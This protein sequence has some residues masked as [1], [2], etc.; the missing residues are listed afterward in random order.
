MLIPR[1]N[2]AP[3][4]SELRELRPARHIAIFGSTGSIGASTLEI[5]RRHPARF[6]IESLVARSNSATLLAQIREFRPR[7][8]ALADRAAAAE[9]RSLFCAADHEHTTLIEGDAD[10]T[11]LAARRENDLLVA[12]VVGMAGLPAVLAA[13]SAGVDVAL[14]NKESLVCGGELVAHACAASGARVIPVDSEHSAIFQALQGERIADLSR[15]LLTASGGPFLKTPL[16]ELRAV[17]P[18]QAVR[19]PRWNMGP[20]VSIDS[21]TMFNKALEIIEAHW[22]FGL[23]GQAIAVVIH[24]QSI[25]HSAVDFIDGSQIAQLSIP[26]M[27]VAIGYALNYPF[28]RIE[29]GVPLLDLARHGPLEFLPLDPLRF[30]APNLAKACIA[31]GGAASAVFN[32][33]NELAV[34][35]FMEGR[36]TFDRIGVW[37][38]V[39]LERFAGRGCRSFAELVEL[40]RE[41]AESFSKNGIT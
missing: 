9:L 22:L 10:I 12:A 25:L 38:E 32:I 34:V 4:S 33:A 20:K 19:H 18:T 37:C 27:R 40:E 23:P 35:A 39:A 29:S 5:V 2:K 21:A 17:T 7:Y 3:Q 14:A 31:N 1:A 13:L 36:V 41:I 30:P 26:D 6:V 24:P 15:I 28:G 8:A 16:A 11:A